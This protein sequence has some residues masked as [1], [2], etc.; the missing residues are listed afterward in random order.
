MT[1]EF[2]PPDVV[3]IPSIITSRLVLRGWRQADIEPYL[4]MAVH[5]D[6]SLYTSSPS[7]AGSVWGMTA[8]QIGHWALNGF[9]MWIIEDRVTGEFLGRA[10]LYEEHGWP[11]IEVAW[12]VRR[13]QWGRGIATE[14]ARAALEFAFVE[15]GRD[16][17]ISIIH[18]KNAA[19]IRVAEKLGLTLAE[20]PVDRGG[21]PRNI[22]AISREEWKVANRP[23]AAE[24]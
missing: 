1:L 2:G 24:S 12:T 4:A 21:E 5:P 23:Q 18:P 14:G 10:G 8:F 16:R 22:Y 9:G 20:G 19:S 13:D 11:D 17:V 6:M 15:A 3:T 7:S